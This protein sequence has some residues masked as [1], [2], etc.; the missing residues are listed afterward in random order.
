[1]RSPSFAKGMQDDDGHDWSRNKTL[2][3]PDDQ[4]DLTDAE[5]SEEIPKI[6]TT[7]NTNAL[8]N[9][10]VYSFKEGGFVPVPPQDNTVTLFQY[11]GTSIH[12]DAPEASNQ[13]SVNLFGEG[14]YRT[15]FVTLKYFII[16][17]KYKQTVELLPLILFKKNRNMQVL[18]K[19]LMKGTK[20]RPKVFL[21]TI[22]NI[23]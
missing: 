3:R 6:L 17:L 21:K 10:V 5:L 13:Q 20:M 1:M 4:L 2:L 15:K 14:R 16:Y 18:M 11:I 8:R 19:R 22:F 23:F 9:L 7:D 12:K